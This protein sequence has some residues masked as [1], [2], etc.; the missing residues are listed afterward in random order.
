[1]AGG[2]GGEGGREASI[3]PVCS[4]HPLSPVNTETRTRGESRN[5]ILSTHIASFF[6]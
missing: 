3:S 4:D 2:G 6:T 1:M 5:N